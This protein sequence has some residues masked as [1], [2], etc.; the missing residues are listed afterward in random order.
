MANDTYRAALVCTKGCV[1]TNNEDNFYFMGEYM[2]LNRMDQGDHLLWSGSNLYQAYAVFDGMGGEDNGEM[3]SSMS[4]EQFAAAQGQMETGDVLNK[5]RDYVR[6]TSESV[7]QDAA[8]RKAHG[9]GSTFAAVIIVNGVAY[10]ANVGDSRVYLMREGKLTVV[11]QDHS[12]V[13]ELFMAG[14]L[15]R[16]QARKHPKNNVITH[17]LGMGSEQIKDDFVY[18]D[19]FKLY[20]KDRLILCSDGICDLMSDATMETLLN[21]ASTPDQAVQSL[22]REALEMGGKDNATCICVEVLDKQLRKK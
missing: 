15:T 3:A 1:R 9:Q 20:E 19:S 14:R 8:K 12:Y 21:A 4:A 11:S 22:T 7:A 6:E 2:P 18:T 17:F 16:E 10:I 5:I 13:Y